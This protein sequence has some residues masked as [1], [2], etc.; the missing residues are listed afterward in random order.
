MAKD[1]RSSFKGL[2][3]KK[4]IQILIALLFIAMGLIGFS[5]N[6]S[7]GGQ[8]SR[9]LSNMFGGDSELLLYIISAVQLLCGLFLAAQLFMPSIP[10]NFV[11]A[12]LLAIWIIWLAMIV[13]LDILTIDFGR[14]R[15]ADWFV[16]IEQTVLH[17]IVLACIM[18]IQ[19]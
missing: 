9:E 16:W 8:L 10:T 3:S 2:A 17:L 18:Q 6:R 13:I 19:E 7:M 14:F 1:L 15:G 12:A 11:K 4:V 5:S